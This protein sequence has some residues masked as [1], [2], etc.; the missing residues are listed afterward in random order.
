MQTVARAL[1]WGRPVVP[2]ESADDTRV[3]AVA[4]SHFHV[5]ITTRVVKLQTQHHEP[6]GRKRTGL[7]E[8]FKIKRYKLNYSSL[9]I[10]L[11]VS[12]LD[13]PHGY[14]GA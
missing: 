12:N 8:T 5:V 1:N 10:I 11:T 14:D 6:V 2:A 4:I 7:K 3:D 13:T 9:Q